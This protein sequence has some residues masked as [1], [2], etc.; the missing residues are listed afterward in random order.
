[1]IPKPPGS[2]RRDGLC[3]R[4]IAGR[5]GARKVLRAESLLDN[6][7]DLVLVEWLRDIVKG[8]CF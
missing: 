8:T 6:D 5:V 7:P 4:G 3:R 2:F 1:M